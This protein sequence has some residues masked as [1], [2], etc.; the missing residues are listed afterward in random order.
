MMFWQRRP[1]LKGRGRLKVW[2]LEALHE[3]N[4]SPSPLALFITLPKTPYEEKG[5]STTHPASIL[6]L[7]FT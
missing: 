2:R 3:V 7:K 5:S 4:E 6:S 1:D